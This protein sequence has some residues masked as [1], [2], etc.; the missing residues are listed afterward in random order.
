MRFTCQVVAGCALWMFLLA[1]MAGAATSPTKDTIEFNLNGTPVSKQGIIKRDSFVGVELAI[2]PLK[3]TPKRNDIIKVTYGDIDNRNLDDA[4]SLMNSGDYKSSI[5]RLMRVLAS[6]NR[7]AID[8]QKPLAKQYVAYYLGMCYFRLAQEAAPKTKAQRDMIN[9]AANIF[10]QL[11]AQ[12][13]DTAFYFEAMLTEAKCREYKSK[14]EA[15]MRYGFLIKDFTKTVADADVRWAAKY[16]FLARIGELRLTAEDLLKKEKQDS[17]VRV[18]LNSLNGIVESPD[19]KKYAGPKERSEAIKIKARLLSYL[20]EYVPLVKILNASIYDSQKNND[21][22]ALRVLYITRADSYY[23]LISQTPDSESELS[24]KAMMD[25]LRALE[26]FKISGA[27]EARANFRCG[28]LMMKLQVKDW[29]IRSKDLL[30]RGMRSSDT[31]I[32]DEAR[33][34]LDEIA[35]MKADA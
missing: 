28:K 24:A 18:Q 4:V 33:K 23:A 35:K 31:S 3:H 11:V 1:D 20:K 25:Y 27:D 9:K 10:D 19:W 26:V 7:M 17:Q 34:L 21:R 29:K 30:K 8:A 22:E 15:K 12:K 32:Q 6:I 5:Q 2:G 14:S 13:P 16:T